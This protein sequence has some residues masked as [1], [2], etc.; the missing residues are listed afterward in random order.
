MTINETVYKPA[1]SSD[2][3]IE[4]LDNSWLF[5]SPSVPNW[6]CVD[7][8]GAMI[9]ALCDGRATGA[10][11]ALIVSKAFKLDAEESRREVCELL[12]RLSRYGFFSPGNEPP[13]HLHSPSVLQPF[14]VYYNITNRCNLKCPYCYIDAGVSLEDELCEDEVLGVID[15]IAAVGARV[16]VISGGEPL[17]RE[18]VFRIAVYA[19]K[20]KGLD[21]TLLTNGT[22][23]TNREIASKVVTSFDTVQV[24]LDGS[25]PGIHDRLRGRGTFRKTLNAIYLIKNCGGQ[26]KLHISAVMTASNAAALPDLMDF[27]GKHKLGRFSA[28][29][30]FPV[31]RGSRHR[32][33]LLDDEEILDCWP[34]LPNQETAIR[35]ETLSGCDYIDLPFSPFFKRSN[36]GIGCGV[37]SIAANGDIYPCHSMHTQTFKA[38]SLKNSSLESVYRDS[39][40][41]R[42]CREATVDIIENCRSCAFRYLCGGG[43]RASAYCSTGSVTSP[44]PLCRSIKSIIKKKLEYEFQHTCSD[45]KSGKV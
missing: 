21:V 28:S 15:Q 20:E 22:L 32:E 45:E 17:L 24:S 23:I 4:E 25:S 37:L 18:D 9:L 3:V 14:M 36:C 31:G 35:N 41:L 8:A 39:L 19:K 10:D 1:I 29:V 43:C 38:G 44:D 6:I 40:V 33:L 12:E 34:S 13:P 26:K 27:V 5:I 30:F 11:I 7:A 42:S 2:Y 16:L